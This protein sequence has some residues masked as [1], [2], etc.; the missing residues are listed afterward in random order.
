METPSLEFIKKYYKKLH[1]EWSDEKIDL[2]ANE[3]LKNYLASNSQRIERDIK[4]SKEM[5]EDALDREFLNMYI[6]WKSGKYDH[7]NKS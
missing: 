5:L 4:E 6:E 7:L 3:T 1:K 2:K